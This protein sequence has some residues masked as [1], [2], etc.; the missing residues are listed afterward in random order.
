MIPSQLARLGFRLVLV[1]RGEKIPLERDWQNAANYSH[2][3][4]KLLAHLKAGGNYGI[5]CGRRGL[6]V[7]DF[8][9]LEKYEEISKQLPPTLVVKTPRGY[10]HHFI[11]D[12][13]VGQKFPFGDVKGEGGYVLGPGCV[14]NGKTYECVTTNPIAHSTLEKIQ[15]I[16]GVKENFQK[17]DYQAAFK[18]TAPGNR[19]DSLFKLACSLKTRGVEKPE[20]FAALKTANENNNPPLPEQEL[21]LIV[22]SAYKY[23]H[24]RKKTDE[25]TII[26][27]SFHIDEQHIYEEVNQN[28]KLMFARYDRNNKKIDYVDSIPISDEEIIVPQTGEEIAKEAILLPTHA[29]PYESTEALD[30]EIFQFTEKW[31]DVDYD[32]RVY[33]VLNIRFSWL[34]DKFNTLNYSRALGD[35]GTGK[36]RFLRVIGDISY[37]PMK[38]AGALTPAVIFRIIDKWK[39]TLVIDEAD[40]KDSEA[41]EAFIKIINCGYE[42]GM[43]VSR[44]DK[45]NLNNIQFFDTYCPKVMSTRRAFQD[46]ATEAR[47]ITTTMRETSRTDI[48]EVLTKKYFEETALL[49]NKLLYYRLTNYDIINPEAGM[50]IN[51]S[52]FEPRLRQ[53]NRSFLGLFA[54]DEKLVNNFKIFLRDYQSRLIEE[55]GS[56]PEGLIINSIALLVAKD[57]QLI[58]LNLVAETVNEEYN[59]KYEVKSFNVGKKLR[60]FNIS[61]ISRKIDGKTL[62]I[63]D[64]DDSHLKNNLSTLFKRYLINQDWGEV[65]D[66]KGYRV[67]GVTGV[68]QTAI[69]IKTDNNAEKLQEST[70]TDSTVTP[71]TT[72]TDI[73]LS[74]SDVEDI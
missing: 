63:L 54:H 51:L 45:E 22:E 49:R 17:V 31:L 72:V 16:L 48:P 13:P 34:Y 50:N 35:T 61:F 15:N 18:G 65:L 44:I 29:E 69:N 28:G 30:E 74:E 27:K 38:I 2:D 64:L 3:D 20:V 33:L 47:C 7:V 68:T 73:F 26:E 1:K 42:K 5:L 53:I 70:L 71:V 39:G 23:Q 24:T 19:N 67:T 58:T 40:Q 4:P 6:I 41:T 55:R 32:S 46:K 9:S 8:D 25:K 59:P 14:V 37:K 10:H 60:P 57:Y 56:T 21:N 11:V 12:K 62:R 36:S 66:S 43:P 52:E